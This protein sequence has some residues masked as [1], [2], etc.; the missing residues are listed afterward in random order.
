MAK[1]FG[2]III[3]I[4]NC[5]GCELCIDSCPQ[6][7]LALAPKINQKGYHYAIKVQDNCTGCLNCALVCPEGIINVYRKIVK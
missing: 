5:K 1:A 3:D 6:N 2:E 4:D 7:T